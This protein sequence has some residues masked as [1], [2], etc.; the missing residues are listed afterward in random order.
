MITYTIYFEEL[1][2]HKNTHTMLTF[3]SKV[4]ASNGCLGL[5]W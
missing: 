3:F 4:Y 2:I 5:H 1:Q